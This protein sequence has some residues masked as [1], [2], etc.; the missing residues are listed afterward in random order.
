MIARIPQPA[1][2]LPIINTRDEKFLWNRVRNECW[3]GKFSKELSLAID[4]ATLTREAV[5]G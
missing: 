4:R 5:H 2:I 3:E 1:N